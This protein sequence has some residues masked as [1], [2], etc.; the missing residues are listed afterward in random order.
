MPASFERLT[1][2]GSWS[3]ASDDRALVAHQAG[4]ARRCAHRGG[5]RRS[6]PWCSRLPGG[7]RATEADCRL[8]FHRLTELELAERGFRDR[9]L[10]AHKERELDAL[11]RQTVAQCVGKRLAPGARACIAACFRSGRSSHDVSA[12]RAA[13]LRAALARPILR[14]AG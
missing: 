11:F 8:I 9:A 3:V 5:P 12:T 2:A 7:E 6:P 14:R 10:V 4:S 13:T 1:I